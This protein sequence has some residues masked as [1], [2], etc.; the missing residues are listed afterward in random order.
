M[1]IN[2]FAP[3][4]LVFS[5]PIPKRNGKTSLSKCVGHKKNLPGVVVQQLVDSVG[6]LCFVYACFANDRRVHGRSEEGASHNPSVPGI[7]HN[8]TTDA[9]F[10]QCCA[11][12]HERVL[13]DESIWVDALIIGSTPPVTVANEDLVRGSLLETQNVSND[14]GGD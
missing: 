11:S 13:V 2:F 10:Q 14:S 6:K 8:S 12:N 1:I 5:S 7:S 4:R 3:V 9:V